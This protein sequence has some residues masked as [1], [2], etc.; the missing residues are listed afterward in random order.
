MEWGIKNITTNKRR[1]R[2]LVTIQQR[3][4]SGEKLVP[5]MLD[6]QG[7]QVLKIGDDYNFNM[8]TYT[9]TEIGTDDLE[10]CVWILRKIKINLS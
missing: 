6:A 3:L 4:A 5:N 1:G 2:R 8:L 10:G 9:V 7:Q